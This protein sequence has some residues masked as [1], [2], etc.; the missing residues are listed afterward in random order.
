MKK[1]HGLTASEVEKSR[2]VYGDNRLLGQKKHSFWKRLFHNFQD[3][4]IR[5]LVIA[6]VLNV[7]FTV[8]NINWMECIG[9]LLAILVSTVVS[10]V[11]EMGSEN[12]FEKLSKE[13][14]DTTCRVIR[15]GVG[16]EISIDDVVV[17]DILAVGVGEAVPADGVVLE[18]ELLVNQAAL[19]GESRE[20]KKKYCKRTT[21]RA[22]DAE[23]RLFRGSLITRGS[24]VIR[25]SEVGQNTFLG[26]VAKDLSEDTR[27]SPLKL[28]LSKLA[29]T[30]SKIGYILA[31]VVA[32]S[33]LFGVIFLDTGFDKNAIISLLFDYRTL[34]THL[35]RALTLAVTIV[36]V[37]V[38]EG[39]P[40]MICVVL[41]S[42]MKR[43]LNDQILV[44][45]MVG[46]ETAGSLNILFSDKTGTFTS[47]KQDVKGFLF[48][49]NRY[50]DNI[51][52]L[53]R[54]TGYSHL[55]ESATYNTECELVGQRVM[56]SNA[57]DRAINEYF[58]KLTKPLGMIYGG[59]PF[60]SRY[61]YS[62]ALTPSG[63]VL[64]KGAPEVLLPHVTSWISS[65]GIAYDG[66]LLKESY[67]RYTRDSARLLMIAIADRLPTA[68]D[69]PELSFVAFAVIRDPLRPSTKTAVKMLQGAG[70]QVVMV[71]GDSPETAE[72]VA[73]A[74]GLFQE[75]SEGTVITGEELTRLTD[76]ELAKRLPYISVVARA[77]PRDKTRLVRVAQGK[78]LVVGMTGDGVND[79]PAL[80][81]ADVGFAMGS[82]TDIAKEAGDIVILDNDM[83]AMVKA[84]LYGRTIFKSICKFIIFQLTMNLCAVGVTLLGPLL[85]VPSPITVIQMLWVNMIMDTLGGLAFAGEAPEKYT[86]EEKPKTRREPLLSR[87]SF[88]KVLW[89]GTTALTVCALFMALDFF[90]DALHFDTVPAVYY[91]ALFS[92]FIFMGVVMF[93]IARSERLNFL[94]G[95][96]KNTSFL[97]IT[98]LVTVVQLLM[99]YFGGSVF[100]T[101]G[102]P[103]KTLCS[104]ALLAF[105]VL[106]FDL[107]RRAIMKKR[108]H[109]A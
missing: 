34:F 60:D 35:I 72:A 107:I 76:C 86:L 58:L 65:E 92:L 4:I 101:V 45:K 46:I 82:G 15:N 61:K 47:G 90:K 38:P 42:N 85:G 10:T 53:K 41:S 96:L 59:I 39:L 52:R 7:A 104:I 74:S 94:S 95:L 80:K 32:M 100:R 71:T 105:I 64:I 40:M 108:N 68:I 56:G 66:A 69:F 99:V 16:E 77:L 12:A 33:Y 57:S 63:T 75:N 102:L 37:A 97:L 81:L 5:V 103:L 27:S 55:L 98:V 89:N 9:I 67:L 25:V 29:A 88:F 83:E 19:N 36:V 50:V 14:R 6:L 48:A 31:A 22:L 23:N 8:H 1:Y 79:A 84:V 24:A 18:G 2:A 78:D 26:D 70:I 62:A 28:R 93:Y 106:P 3:P 44:K 73:R 91:S 30:V 11:S 20:T 13:S 43:M 49:N 51:E 54:E 17:G 21:E 109:G 87:Q